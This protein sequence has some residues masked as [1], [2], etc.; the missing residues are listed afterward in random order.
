MGPLELRAGGRVE[1]PECLSQ[2]TAGWAAARAA[3]TNE[4]NTPDEH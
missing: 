4:M 1:K 3:E 2:K